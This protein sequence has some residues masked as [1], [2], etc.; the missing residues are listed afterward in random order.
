[1]RMNNDWK[2]RRIIPVIFEDKPG[3]AE[4]ARLAIEKSRE[5]NKEGLESVLLPPFTTLRDASYFF[6]HTLSFRDRMQGPRGNTYYE[7][8]LEIYRNKKNIL[9][10]LAD[11]MMPDVPGGEEIPA[12][13]IIAA[14]ARQWNLPVVVCSSYFHGIEKTGWIVDLL[15]TL[16]VPFLENKDWDVAVQLLR[17][18]VDEGRLIFGPFASRDDV[19]SVLNLG[20]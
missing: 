3:E 2:G 20:H 4:K 7:S 6:G 13:A 8:F 5:N 19:L 15:W 17:K 12:G 16:D 11:L 18:Q 9:G 10:I 14:E 1:M